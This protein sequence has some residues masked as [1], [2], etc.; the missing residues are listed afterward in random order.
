MAIRSYPS[1]AI[2]VNPIA[3]S[4]PENPRGKRG[5]KFSAVTAGALKTCLIP[6]KINTE[7]ITIFAMVMIFS[8]FPVAWVPMMFTVKK[9]TPIKTVR[10]ATEGSFPRKFITL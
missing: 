4:T 1:K 2:K 10:I 5:V 8:V 7:R 3:A 9:R 6:K